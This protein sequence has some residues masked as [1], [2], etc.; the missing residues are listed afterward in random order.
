MP[1]IHRGPIRRTRICV[2]LMTLERVTR[3]EGEMDATAML[4]TAVLC[5][6][7]M[8]E[9][10][11]DEVDLIE[12]NHFYDDRGRLVFDQ[13]IFYD[14]YAHEGRFQV[15]DW[16]LLKS[17]DQIPRRNWRRGNFLTIWTDGEHLREVWSKA[18]HE[19]WTQYDPELMERENLPK[20][21]RLRLRKPKTIMTRMK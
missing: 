4:M 11:I 1:Q 3:K 8:D 10:A 18:L 7:P 20:E 19:T 21:K 13:V 2:L 9:V 6:R 14:W 17:A 15:R 5:L 16:R 12:V